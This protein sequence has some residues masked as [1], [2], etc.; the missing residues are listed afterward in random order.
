MSKDLNL[1]RVLR[2]SPSDKVAAVVEV[3]AVVQ[4]VINLVKD[5]AVSVITKGLR[6]VGVELRKDSKGLAVRAVD[7]A[8]LDA[9][10]AN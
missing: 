2:P 4:Q 8:Q 5:A 7:A 9:I 1:I 10:A 3:A 6:V